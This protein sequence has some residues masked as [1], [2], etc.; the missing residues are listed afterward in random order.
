MFGYLGKLGERNDG[1]YSLADI[2]LIWPMPILILGN[3]KIRLSNMS[4]DIV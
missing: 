1:L 2:G 4:G 3:K